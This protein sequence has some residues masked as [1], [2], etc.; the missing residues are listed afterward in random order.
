MSAAAMI[1]RSFVVVGR[2]VGLFEDGLP[3]SGKGFY[4][5][6]FGDEG[7]VTRIEALYF[8]EDFNT[9]SVSIYP[10]PGKYAGI[11]YWLDRAR[12]AMIAA[13][14]GNFRVPVKKAGTVK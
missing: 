6:S 2:R 1:D 14:G 13:L 9:T 5:L 12:T 10:T 7:N 8:A 3:G 4:V 11:D